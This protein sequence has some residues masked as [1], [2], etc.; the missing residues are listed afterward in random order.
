MLVQERRNI[1]GGINAAYV[2][3]TRVLTPP[4]FRV[5]QAIW[6]IG[7]L[8]LIALVIALTLFFPDRIPFVWIVS[9]LSFIV[10]LTNVNDCFKSLILWLILVV[11]GSMLSTLIVLE[12]ALLIVGVVVLTSLIPV[13]IQCF[14]Q[15]TQNS[16]NRNW[17][18][19]QIVL[20]LLI[21]GLAVIE[22]GLF[23]SST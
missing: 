13:A 22:Q 23:L 15:K 5:L 11:S 14:K 21:I 3:V 6:G 10:F 17:L 20:T 19:I 18:V 2:S 7:G 9:L 1:S 16:Q 12:H 8:L 4:M